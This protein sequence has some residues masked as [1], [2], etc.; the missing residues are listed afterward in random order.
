M[1]IEVAGPD[2]SSFTF[3]DGTPEA[4]ITDA[5]SAHYGAPEGKP[6]DS[7]SKSELIPDA[8]KARYDRADPRFTDG[9]AA[10]ALRGVPV[11]G[12]LVTNRAAAAISSAAHPLTG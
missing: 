11:V 12:P 10:A 5:L 9:S 8:V 6:S 3:P 4:T 2:G 1:T 7:L